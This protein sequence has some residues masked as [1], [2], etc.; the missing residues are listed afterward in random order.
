MNDIILV[1][2][3]EVTPA[4]KNSKSFN[5]FEFC[6]DSAKNKQDFLCVRC[7]KIWFFSRLIV[8]WLTP[9][10]LPLGKTQNHLVF[11]SLNRTLSF[12]RS[13]SR[14]TIKIKTRFH[15]V[16]CSL[17]RNFAEKTRYEQPACH[18]HRGGKGCHRN[19]C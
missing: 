11:L 9:K 13:Y 8:I 3:L 5:Y 19:H 1:A 10:L 15:F 14:S 6:L 12:A 2:L 4:R 16:L 18:N 17:N 7:S